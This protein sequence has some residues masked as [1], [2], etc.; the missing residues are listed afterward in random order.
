MLFP[1]DFSSFAPSADFDVDVEVDWKI[2]PA[3]FRE[4]WVICYLADLLENRVVL[5]PEENR[6]VYLTDDAEAFP[7]KRL[8]QLGEDHRLV[9]TYES[10]DWRVDRLP[11]AFSDERSITRPDPRQ[12][13]LAPAQVSDEPVRLGELDLSLVPGW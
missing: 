1:F 9:V 6:V 7:R 2:E 4:P 5:E 3:F 10:L 13:T 8:H 11:L 12:A